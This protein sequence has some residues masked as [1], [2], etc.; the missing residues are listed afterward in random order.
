[1]HDVYLVQDTTAF[2]RAPQLRNGDIALRFGLPYKE[3]LHIVFEAFKIDENF[4]EERRA[5]LRDGKAFLVLDN[6][7][8]ELSGFP[9]FS[10]IRSFYTDAIFEVEEIPAFKDELKQLRCLVLSSEGRAGIEKLLRICHLAMDSSRAIFFL[11]K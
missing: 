7:A 11:G 4:D 1:M 2:A 9:M 6:D 10:R 8:S 3:W 5:E